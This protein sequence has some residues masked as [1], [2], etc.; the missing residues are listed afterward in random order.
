MKDQSA[1]TEPRPPESAS[2]PE[3]TAARALN[4]KPPCPPAGVPAITDL[5]LPMLATPGTA[6][7]V[8]GPAGRTR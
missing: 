4:A 6:D 1:P 7:G 3:P 2:E 8:T 5:P